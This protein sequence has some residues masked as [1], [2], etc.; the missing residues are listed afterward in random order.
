MNGTRKSRAT[1]DLPLCFGRKS[2][3]SQHFVAGADVSGPLNCTYSLQ[4]TVITINE[5]C[6]NFALLLAMRDMYLH[7]P[8]TGSP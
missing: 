7:L 4:E 1:S 5:I 6:T 8:T 3:H 2:K